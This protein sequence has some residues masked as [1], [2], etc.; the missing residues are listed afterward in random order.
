[1]SLLGQAIG[2]LMEFQGGI[3]VITHGVL[4]SD[5]AAAATAVTHL[6]K[7]PTRLLSPPFR[8]PYQ[9]CD[10]PLHR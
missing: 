9:M 2:L 1:M 4:S 7:Q 3:R 8:T 6:P 10:V 5:V